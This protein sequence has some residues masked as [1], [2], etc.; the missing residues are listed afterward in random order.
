MSLSP[1]SLIQQL[2]SL[3]HTGQLLVDKFQKN[4]Q[5]IHPEFRESLKNFLYYLAV[6]KQDI[7]QMQRQLGKLGI[8]RLG[9]AESHV[10]AS[11]SAI[12]NNLLR[13]GE[14]TEGLITGFEGNFEKGHQI[15]ATHAED[16]LGPE[17]KGRASRIMVTLPSQA[18]TDYELVR[19]IIAADISIL[20]INCAHDEAEDWGKMVAHIKKAEAE[21]G[22]DVKIAM[23]LAGPKLRTGSLPPGPRVKKIRPAKNAK[24]EVS[25][26]AVFSIG[27]AE[28][29]GVSIPLEFF[30]DSALP[31]DQIKFKDARQKKRKLT[32]LKVLDGKLLVQA[33]KNTVFESGGLLS[34]YREKDLIAETR[35]GDLP[36]IPG[37]LSL[38]I[39]DSLRLHLEEKEGRNASMEDGQLHPASISCAIPE[40]YASAKVGEKILLDDGTIE[41]F[42][43]EVHSE[44]L[45]IKLTHTKP[46]GSK[47]KADKGINLPE[48]NLNLSGLTDKDKLDLDFVAHHAD[49]VNMS[50]VNEPRDVEDL[51]EALDKQGVK[52]KI[53]IVLKIETR[54]GYANL[55]SILITAMQTYPLGVMIA[56]GDL[57][58]ECGWVQLAEV[59]EEILRI[60]EAAHVPIIWATQV[61]EGLAKTGLPSRAE[62]TDAA[63]SQR[64]EC[65]MLNKGPFI[66]DAINTLDQ[67][68]RNMQDIHMKKAPMLA[69]LEMNLDV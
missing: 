27:L 20:R 40:L 28:V 64:A 60:C 30:P 24:G 58:V 4:E 47:L 15:L 7:R 49:I 55:P 69:G 59:Q 21:L 10:L 14:E 68:L 38:K 53:G 56:R 51:L 8:S 42:I 26:P 48:T 3:E 45:L 34:L 46:Q 35:V 17:I 2:S 44:E 41:G 43:E 65:V 54:K 5:Q 52:D 63:M 61:L 57:A 36:S 19:D 18:A 22:V 16:L 33:N 67:I 31:G 39:G 50:F 62:I 32:V 37:Y 25:E 9:R 1:S 66:L 12:R 23:D 11:I 29:E 6:R 13:L